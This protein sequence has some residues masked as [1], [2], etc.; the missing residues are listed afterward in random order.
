MITR[1]SMT[2]TAATNV[3]ATMSYGAANTS[4]TGIGGG[5]TL[6]VAA[7]FTTGQIA[8]CNLNTT[9]DLSGYQQISFAMSTNLALSASVLRIDLCS[10]TAG[11][12]PVNSFTINWAMANVSQMG[13]IVLDYG[14]NLSNAIK[15]IA[16]TALS[17]PGT[18]S[19]TFENFVACKASSDNAAFNHASLI[20]KSS[21]GTGAECWYAISRIHDNMLLLQHG[22]Q[23][24]QTNM[25][26]G[27]ARGYWGT[28]ETSSVYRRETIHN[29]RLQGLST[30]NGYFAE[31]SYI[32]ISG[33][34]DR[35]NM[36]TRNDSTFI[37][38]GN[39]AVAYQAGG[40][41]NYA[42]T[43]STSSNV[44]VSGLSAV[45]C[46]NAVA[47]IYSTFCTY[48][49]DYCIAS[50]QLCA[51]GS[52]QAA[53]QYNSITCSYVNCCN[54]GTAGGWGFYPFDV[55][56][57]LNCGYGIAAS[58]NAIIKR[59]SGANTLV[60]NCYCGMS[61]AA[62]SVSSFMKVYNTTFTG[63]ANDHRGNNANGSI[64]NNLTYC[65]NCTFS[66]TVGASSSMGTSEQTGVF[67]RKE[68]GDVNVNKIYVPSGLM[69]TV[70]DSN[71]RT[72]S[73]LAWKISPTTSAQ[74]ST[75]PVLLKLATIACVANTS[76][77][78]SVYAKRDTSSINATYIAR[79]GMIGGV[80]SDVTT[81]LSFVP[82]AISSSTNAS[83]IQIT[84]S[85][86]H[87]LS[88]G[89]QIA[90]QNHTTN[91]AAN[92]N[93][94]ITV[95]DSTKFTLNGS[96][97]VGVGSSGTVTK[98]ENLSLNFTPNENGIIDIFMSCWGGTTSNVWVDDM[99]VR[100]CAITSNLSSF[101]YMGET[102][103]LIPPT[104]DADKSFVF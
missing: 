62:S 70:A 68:G 61:V 64:S 22:G 95:V 75:F 91:T 82:I 69:Q 39:L 26:S 60:A 12:V 89:D 3:T 45:R 11:A 8:Y 51:T 55:A 85:T 34:W 54:N 40:I 77:T 14:A 2:W 37:D 65:Y 93:W 81:S 88:T 94:T 18:V 99:T 71:R 23:N 104:R 9:L 98:W 4:F 57:I 36:S 79:G 7:A 66:S 78:V 87:G 27:I 43:I 16:I 10:D 59:A 49:I 101:E 73:G 38:H 29:L 96:T 100:N 86:S 13:N 92:G 21:V 80:N 50:T 48:S 35:T 74:Y 15:S 52:N 90:I 19:F 28:T 32:T 103:A 6:A 56:Y 41:L 24:L 102:G 83:P 84:T 17:D 44:Q 58:I 20:G 97:G 31:T 30:G 53:T 72:A 33:G 42:I 46:G 1:P 25:P 67:S 76:T 5:V 63:N 47:H